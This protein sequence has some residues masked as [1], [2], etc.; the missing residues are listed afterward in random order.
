MAVE[1]LKNEHGLEFVKLSLPSRKTSCTVALY[2]AHLTSWVTDGD[3]ENLFMSKTAILDG[4]KSIRG[5]I[6]V[7]FPQ[8]GPGKLPQ[9]GFARTSKWTYEGTNV[10]QAGERVQVQLGLNAEAV[11]SDLRA[12]WPFKFK[13]TYCV[14]LLGDN[15][16]V[17]KLVVSNLETEKDFNF[18]CLLHP[19]FA[20]PEIGQLAVSGLQGYEYFDKVIASQHGSTCEFTEKASLVEFH[21]EVDR[22][23]RSIS[24]NQHFK[25]ID[26][27]SNTT[28]LT[29]KNVQPSPAANQGFKDVVL[30]NPS[31]ACAP[32]MKDLHEQGWRNFVCV[33]LGHVS[34]PVS[35]KP[36]ETFEAVQELSL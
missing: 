14:D 33:E 3:R 5:G 17:C 20:I 31:A 35:L 13:L 6:P 15:R 23:Y 8:F 4:T 11:A 28:I 27:L 36:N 18:T 1:F 10:I 9:H 16:L 32:T 21:G 12:E 7:V 29:V 26:R 34:K 25:L 2:G 22:V 30:W 19:Y 24:P